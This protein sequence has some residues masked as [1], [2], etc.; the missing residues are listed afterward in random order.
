MVLHLKKTDINKLNNQDNQSAETLHL[1]HPALD[2]TVFLVFMVVVF[3][4]FFFFMMSFDIKAEDLY[5]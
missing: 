3:L 4:L 5:Y 1:K 2:L